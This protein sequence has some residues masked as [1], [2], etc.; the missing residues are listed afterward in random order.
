MVNRK[1]T[2]TINPH[3]YVIQNSKADEKDEDKSNKMKDLFG[4]AVREQSELIPIEFD[5]TLT[6]KRM[7]SAH[8]INK[9]VIVDQSDD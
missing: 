1:P 4:G 9:I 8:Q 2:R 6:L 7:K 3:L 5:S